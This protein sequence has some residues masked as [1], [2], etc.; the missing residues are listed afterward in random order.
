MQKNP[1]LRRDAWA[2][3]RL[4]RRA[5][6]AEH[7]RKRDMRFPDISVIPYIYLKYDNVPSEWLRL[8]AG[9][10]SETACE[11]SVTRSPAFLLLGRS[12]P[13]L[14]SLRGLYV[15]RARTVVRIGEWQWDTDYRRHARR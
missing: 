6:D 8:T 14:R 9:A 15:R 5:V 10:A 11:G 12:L 7:K 2:G 4:L 3:L 13:G 1:P